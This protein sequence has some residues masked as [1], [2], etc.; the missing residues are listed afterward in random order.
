MFVQVIQ[1]RVKDAAGIDAAVK[2]W[3]EKLKPG[4]KGWLGTTSGIT[5]DNESVAVVRFDTEANARA[6]S[7]RPEQTAWWK[8]EMS[9]NFEGEPTFFESGEVDTFGKGGSDKA[10]FVQIMKGTT[11]DKARAKELDAEM[12]AANSQ[13]QRPDVIGGITAWQGDDFVT[14][15]YFTSE[16][17]ARAGEAKGFEGDVKAAVEEMQAITADLKFIDLTEPKLISA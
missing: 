7:E 16:K 1:G 4:A 3:Q 12:E 9:K 5:K 6:N 17:E 14:V 11:K 2:L 8:N 10:G 15:I 13:E